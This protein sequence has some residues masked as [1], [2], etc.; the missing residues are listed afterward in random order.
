MADRA[1][2][3]GAVLSARPLLC[4]L[5]AACGSA[6]PPAQPPGPSASTPPLRS[7][8]DER[9]RREQ[10]GAAHHKL[11]EE[12]Q[13]AF[14]ATC[15][16]PDGKHERCLPSCYAREPADVRAGKQLAGAVELTHVA[17]EASSAGPLA[18][19]D[20]L[21]PGKLVLRA[22]RG[23]VAAAH[24][25]GTW[26]AEVESALTAAQRPPLARG[27]VLRVSSYWR[28]LV[29]PLTKERLRC[30]TISI[31]GKPMRH[32]LDACGGQGA[33]ACEAT[34]N[35]AAH[36]LNV[37]HYRLAEARALQAAAKP[38]AC[39]QAALEA[40]AV[41]R[42][43]PRWRQYVTLN[44]AKWVAHAGYRTRFDGI[45]DEDTLFATAASLGTEAEL[46]YA[47]CGGPSGAPTTAAQEQSFH[48]C[49]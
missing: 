39:Q 49:W 40:V 16:D 24:K 37:V 15:G 2:V 18:I 1:V 23:R 26:Q 46:V 5:L 29:H 42:G 34:G 8:A 28:D 22:V 12:Q 13:D 21:E 32:A 11:E 25:P 31:Y 44:V 35:A 30:V 36:G 7:A 20:E 9:A 6:S 38:E 17:C 14:A 33:I 10:L 3:S 45:L 41:A 19:V 48:T 47:A 4:A 27:E 43:L